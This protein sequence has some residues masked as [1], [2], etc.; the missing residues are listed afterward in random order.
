MDYDG[1]LELL[2]Y[3][4]SIRKFKPDPIP[5]EYVTKILNA[6][7]LAMSGANSQPWEFVVVKDPVTRK[8]LYSAYLKHYEQVWYLEQMRSVE[9]RQAAFSVSAEERDKTLAMIG[10][11]ADAPVLIVV[12]E[13]PRKQFGSVLQAFEPPARVLTDSMSHCTMTLHLAAAALGLGS[14]RVDIHLEVPFREILGYPE[15][16]H[17]NVLIPIG[18][19][20][21]EPGTPHRLPLEELVHYEKYDMHKYLKNKDF[22]NYML[23]IRALGKP[24]YRVTVGEDK[25]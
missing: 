25:G 14:Q 13:D 24:G 12:L 23:R 11:W 7:H 2:N 21:Y 22:L 5:D 16:L 17:L 20:A 6:A 4:R 9:Y 15:P 19:R 18:Y 10:G 1:F 3:R 8:K